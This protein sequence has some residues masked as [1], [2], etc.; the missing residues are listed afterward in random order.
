M[1]GKIKKNKTKED[2]KKESRQASVINVDKLEENKEKQEHENNP[3]LKDAIRENM[4]I[5]PRET[6]TETIYE[7]EK[8]KEND[9]E[10]DEKKIIKIEVKEAKE[11]SPNANVQTSAN[12]QNLQ[13]QGA[14]GFGI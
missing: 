6:K 7:A 8:G 14:N 11:G 3:L 13:Q 9:K 10:K 1:K 5:I 2:S 12:K 4:P